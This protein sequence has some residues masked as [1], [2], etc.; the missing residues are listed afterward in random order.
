MMVD[1]L[2][3][4]Q[5][6]HHG[7]LCH[8]IIRPHSLHESRS[9]CVGASQ[10]P[11]VLEAP[12]KFPT[13]DL[14]RQSKRTVTARGTLTQTSLM[15]SAA[16]CCWSKRLSLQSNAEPHKLSQKLQLSNLPALRGN[17]Y[18]WQ[19]HQMQDSAI[20]HPVNTADPGVPSCPSLAAP[21]S[22]L[23][24]ARSRHFADQTPAAAAQSPHQPCF[25]RRS[26]GRCS[27]PHL[28]HVA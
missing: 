28:D 23:C 13:I 25:I 21:H 16:A 9:I 22:L 27:A 14:Q 7:D 1:V 18:T 10:V 5:A 11:S 24:A 6:R 17:R 2:I 3:A 8:L 26:A 20:D 12:V 19:Q 15:S 4:R